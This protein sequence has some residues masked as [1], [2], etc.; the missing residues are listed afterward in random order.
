MRG[1]VLVISLCLAAGHFAAGCVFGPSSYQGV[2]GYREGRVF[3]RRDNT[4]RVGVLPEGWQRMQTKAR[5]ISF[6]NPTYKSSISTDA[7]CGSGDSNRRLDALG[8]DIASALENRTLIEEKSF[9]L[10]GRGALRQRIGGF[11]DGV[12]VEVDLV[13]VRKDGCVFDFYSVSPPG[14][15]EGLTSDFEAF[16]TAFEYR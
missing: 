4:Y 14:P 11:Q 9:M 10:D 5:A 16:F 2:I 13:V 3:I 12:E 8:G 15:P 7:Y 1:V 6:Y